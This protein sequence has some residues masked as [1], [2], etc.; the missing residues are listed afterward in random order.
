L[1]VLGGAVSFLFKELSLKKQSR[2]EALSREKQSREEKLLRLEEKRR[3]NN[4]RLREI[5]SDLLAAFNQAK[6][7]R[8]ILKAFVY[9]ADDGVEMIL[10][11][12]YDRQMQELNTA[13]LVFETYSKRAKYN[14][15]WFEK[16]KNL[17][18][19]IDAIEGYLNKILSEYQE[20]RKLFN[21]APPSYPISELQMLKEF[22]GP[23]KEWIFFDEMFKTPIRETLQSLDEARL[24]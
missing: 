9:F 4:E 2:E 6:T 11:D 18:E 22:I 16:A 21:G 15:L 20:K 10:R 1:A 3:F 7:V 5:H 12:D 13:Q 19:N 17:S 8:R 14:K 23:K 24:G